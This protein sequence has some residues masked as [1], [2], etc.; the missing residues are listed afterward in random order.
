[1]KQRRRLVPTRSPWT[2]PVI[3]TVSSIALVM[4]AA[5]GGQQVLK[6]Q[7]SGSG[8]PIE[9]KNASESFSDA[10]SVVVDDPAVAA[11]GDGEGPR[12]VKHF[13]RDEPFNMFAVTWEGK[14]DVHSFVR[15]KQEDGSW[16]EWFDMDAM[17]YGDGKNGTELIYVGDTNDVQVSMANVDLVTG[18]NLDDD[19][20]LLEKAAGAADANRA[21]PLP[22]NVGDIAPVADENNTDRTT[23][24][25]LDAVFMDGNAQ[26]GHAIEP[27][28]TTDGMPKVVSRSGW[29]A[30]ESKRCQQP[31]YDDGIKAMTLHHTAGSNNY[32]PAQAAAQVRAAYEYHAQNLGW[33]DIGYNVLVDKFGTIYEG[34]YGGLDKAVQGAH[35]GGFN[36][37]NWGISM[38]GNYEIAEPSQ[39]MLNS[40]AEIAGWKAAISGIDPTGTA[41]L[42]SGGFG[43]SKYAAGTQA[44]VPAFSGHND[45]HYTQCPGSHTV[46]HWKE[47]RDNT[48]QKYN[49]VKAGGSAAAMNWDKKPSISGGQSTPGGTTSSIG[50]VDIPVSTIQALAGIA[51]AVFG[52]LVANDRVAEP[53]TDKKVAGNLTVGDIPNIVNKVVQL[54]NNEGLKES[55]TSVLNAFGPVLGLAVGGPNSTDSGKIM[56]QLFQNGVVLSSKDSGAKALTGEIAKKWSE[57]NNASKLGLPTTNEI[58]NGKEIRV[59][60]QGGEIVYNIDTEKVDIYTK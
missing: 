45:F 3:A 42:T 46:Q 25:D 35:V 48:K 36:S 59:Q 19:A 56:Y 15:S 30:D 10:D 54:S 24:S 39:K 50:G 28:A 52:V 18:S 14:R 12:A 13:H 47:I 23:V 37:H 40:V 34:R 32:T 5:F 43:G 53:D 29:G 55:W 57:G 4:A 44:T 17:N 7:D 1:M 6:T 51:A 20:E 60:F 38:I 31:T 9:V 21:A 58:K 11:Q 41:T 22:Y 8:G 33:C 2:T 49:A 16:S 26:E 27:T